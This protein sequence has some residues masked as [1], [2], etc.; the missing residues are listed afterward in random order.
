M[1]KRKKK[2]QQYNLKGNRKY[3]DRIFQ[4]SFSKKTDL[5]E[6]YNA[7]NHTEYQN[8]DDLIV[9]TLEYAIFISMK[10]YLSFLI[11][12]TMNLYEHQSTLNPNMPLRGL[13]YLARLYEKYV[14]ENQLNIY[15]TQLQKLPAPR[16]LIFYNGT[17]E[18]PDEVPLRLSDAFDEKQGACL[19]CV[20]TMLNI[21]YGHNRELMEKCR[22]L[23]EYAQF[24]QTVRKCV[25][26]QG[27][28]DRAVVRAVDECIDNEI[29]KDI[30][31]GHRSEVI[32][33]IITSF[34][35]E[36]YEKI[37]LEDAKRL[38]MEE[39][40]KKGIEEGKK[41]G[42]E[43]GRELGQANVNRLNQM[44]LADQ[45]FD[46]LKRSVTNRDFQKQLMEEYGIE[47]AA[48]EV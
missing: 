48:E 24:V 1:N 3:K 25:R 19:E 9:N 20:A 23:E 11:G 42:R 29:L 26:E 7:V 22:R 32:G 38:G 34:R 10:N 13:C 17:E 16:Y 18:E 15:G 36:V 28:F 40:R 44:L 27:S 31:I 4:L 43:E 47:Q 33:M 41:E 46:D 5:L 37:I 45:R 2:K 6:L 39:G 14:A 21:N 12:G 8:A 35:D 30:L